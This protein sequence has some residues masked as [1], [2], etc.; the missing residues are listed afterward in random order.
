MRQRTPS[1][2]ARDVP[3]AGYVQSALRGID[4]RRSDRGTWIFR[5]QTIVKNLAHEGGITKYSSRHGHSYI[6]RLLEDAANHDFRQSRQL[7]SSLCEDSPRRKI[8]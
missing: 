4:Y 5:T 6:G 8:S 1:A 2:S 3:P 7:R